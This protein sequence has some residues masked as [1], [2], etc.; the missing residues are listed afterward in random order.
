MEE[1]NS[2][3][4]IRQEK[5]LRSALLNG[6]IGIFVV[7]IFSITDS[8]FDTAIIKGILFGIFIFF[9]ILL[10]GKISWNKRVKKLQSK[11][12]EGLNEL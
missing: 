6:I 5:T 10:I 9:S 2:L 7:G 11:K 4:K 8:T 3:K 1:K 12:Y